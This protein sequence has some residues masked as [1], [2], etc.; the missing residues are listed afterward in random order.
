MTLRNRFLDSIIDG[1]LGNG[2]TVTRQQFIQFFQDQNPSTTGCF[3]SNSEIVTG[4]PHSPHYS[5]FTI[6]I[7]DGVYRIHPGA[8]QNRMQE[9]GML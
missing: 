7:S 4:S 5:H 1:H 2:I 8:L 3:L 6:R 9:R